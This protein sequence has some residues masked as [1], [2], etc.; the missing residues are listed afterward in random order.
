VKARPN[1]RSVEALGLLSPEALSNRAAKASAESFAAIFHLL[2]FSSCAAAR[3]AWICVS[4]FLPL[5]DFAHR[6]PR[7]QSQNA[8]LAPPRFLVLGNLFF[9]PLARRPNVLS[10][11]GF[12]ARECAVRI[13]ASSGDLCPRFRFLVRLLGSINRHRFSLVCLGL[14]PV[15]EPR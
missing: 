5:I 3:V 12:S 15:F 8:R 1:F 7:R 2:G 11:L 13:V 14:D 9:R 4:V 10:L 6:V